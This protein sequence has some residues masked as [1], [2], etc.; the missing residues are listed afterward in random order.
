YL[1]ANIE[2]D[3]LFVNVGSNVVVK[4]TIPEGKKMIEEQTSKLRKASL[5][6]SMQLE[7]YAMEFQ[8]MLKE[9]N[10]IKEEQ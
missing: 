3:E 4:K 2:N 1:K 8:H 9:L 6:I 10:K 5:E 7:Q